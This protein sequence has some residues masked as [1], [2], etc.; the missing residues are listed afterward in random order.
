MITQAQ[1]QSKPRLLVFVP[2]FPRV[3]ETFIQREI[4]KLIDLGNFDVTVFALQRASGKFLPKVEVHTVY[5]TLSPLV[6]V[7]ALIWV[8]PRWKRLLGAW[9]MYE[10]DPDF[11]KVSR[12][13]RVYFFL[14]AV[15]YSYL[16][17]KYSPDHI[18]ANFMSWPST[19]AWLASTLLE[20]PYS[21]SAHAKD[22]MVDGEF[23]ELKGKTAKFTTIC[24]RYA[25]DFCKKRMNSVP[26]AQVIMQYHGIDPE[27]AFSD[28]SPRE[29][30][31]RFF[32]SNVGSRLVE[33]KGQRYLISAMAL[34]RDWGIDAE[35]HIA[36]PG[37]LY[38]ALM[39]QIADLHLTDSVYIHGEGK[40]I[41]FEEVAA[42]LKACDVVVQSNVNLDSGDADGIPTLVIESAL[43]SKPIIST[44]A[45]SIPELIVDGQTGLVVPQKD[46]YALA[47][48]IARVYVALKNDFPVKLPTEVKQIIDSEPIDPVALGASAKLRAL[49]NFDLTKNV[50]ALEKLLLA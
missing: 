20:I 19:M 21:I 13:K 17:S 4:A 27:K 37:H 44:D 49:E 23:F 26:S 1:T 41:P 50:Q 47:V 6:F 34:L 22:V 48:A 29:R 16:F 2:E 38:D 46:V 12:F 7:K 14:K 8:L 30:S 24:N 9:R 11:S 43:L 39:S 36:G 25:Y 45:G 15:G 5:K 10:A 18:H 32:I 31:E 35:L 28:I 33:K 42:F 40:G 3:T